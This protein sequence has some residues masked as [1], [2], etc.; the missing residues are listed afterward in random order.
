[1]APATPAGPARSDLIAQPVTATDL[2]PLG[3][4]ELLDRAVT[5][6]IRRFAILVTALAIT[7]VPFGF[8]Q[9][10][11]IGSF[12]GHRRA[13]LTRAEWQAF[14]IDLA[15]G[16]LVFALGRTAAAA[17]AHAAYANRTLSL[18]AAYR[19]ALARIGAQLVTMVFGALVGSAIV[20]VAAIPLMVI[21]FMERPGTVPIVVALL[22]AVAI[23]AILGGWLILGFELATVRIATRAENHFTALFA[24][25]RGTAFQ[26]PWRSLLT[27]GILM[28]VV[29]GG[30][31]VFSTLAELMPTQTLR[32]FFTF[33]VGYVSS[34]IIEALT[35]TFLVVYDVDLAVRREGLDLT[36]ALDATP[37]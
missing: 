31:L 36:V 29:I 25:L 11:L 4:G 35:V 10:A 13:T 1:M 21:G 32:T 22:I 9:W 26:R 37:P 14:G 24:A 30:S 18:A 27:A 8:V 2:R 20:I 15:V 34:L 23:A 7:F 12:T 28:L 16:L 19:I 33:G 17:I 5:L 6:F 3:L